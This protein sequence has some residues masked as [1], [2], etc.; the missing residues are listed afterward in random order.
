MG[1]VFTSAGRLDRP[2]AGRVEYGCPGNGSRK[3]RHCSRGAETL[4]T[5]RTPL[6]RGA[7]L[8]LGRESVSLPDGRILE[9]EVLRH[10]GGAAVVA[11]DAEGRV[12]LLRQYRH[13][14]SGWLWEVPAGKLD[15]GEAPDETARRELAEEAGLTAAS[16]LGL[17]SILTTPG[18]CDEVIHLY[19]ARK[20]TP[21]PAS[22]GA[23]EVIEV[24]WVPF[25][26]ALGRAAR[27]DIRDAKTVVAL[28]RAQEALR[29][30]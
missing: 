28:F 29:L 21:V 19:L 1:R 3:E 20:L 30:A 2:E 8:D 17:G 16:W 18:F 5:R 14:G 27:G 24:H 6:Y 4:S 15:P 7:F 11:L 22:P 13:A 26:E 12:C 10:P 25:A 9:L 23:H